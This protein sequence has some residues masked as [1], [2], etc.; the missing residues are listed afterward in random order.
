MIYIKMKLMSINF[1]FIT[2]I[3]IYNK[4]ENFKISNKFN[5]NYALIKL[6]LL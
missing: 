2:D 3:I 4:F 6:Y 5:W 1:Y